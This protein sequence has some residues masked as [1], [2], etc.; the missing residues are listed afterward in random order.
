M[1]TLSAVAHR[2]AEAPRAPDRSSA[3]ISLANRREISGFLRRIG[4]AVLLQ[5]VGA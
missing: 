1:A 5:W 4:V 2:S 3:P